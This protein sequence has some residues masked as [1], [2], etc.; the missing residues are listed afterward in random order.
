MRKDRYIRY[1]ALMRSLDVIMFHTKVTKIIL[2]NI[3]ELTNEYYE[4]AIDFRRIEAEMGT[5]DYERQCVEMYADAEVQ[6]KI[7]V[8]SQQITRV[9]L[10][11]CGYIYVGP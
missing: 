5:V 7:D 4:L 6:A 3:M 2:D 1:V 8:D 9:F 11:K 10:N